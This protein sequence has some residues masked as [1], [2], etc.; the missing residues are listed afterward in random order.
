MKQ[1][2]KFLFVHAVVLGFSLQAQAELFNRGADNLGNRLIYDSDIS[3]TWYD[4]TNSYSTW[5]FQMSW[6]SALTVDFGG[7]IYDDWC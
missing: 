6:A 4:Y 3:I 1:I 7:T 2:F 5:Q